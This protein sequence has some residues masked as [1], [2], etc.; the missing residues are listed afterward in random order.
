MVEC[1]GFVTSLLTSYWV[2]SWLL[3]GE[4]CL[5]TDVSGL[6]IGPVFKGQDLEGETDRE[7]RNVG[8]KPPHAA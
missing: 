2:T 8:L 3:R 7:S 1:W 5:E 6:P 4:R